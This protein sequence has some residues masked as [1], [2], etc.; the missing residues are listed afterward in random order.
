MRI[1]IVDDEQE[2]VNSLQH[3]FSKKG[4]NVDT[5]ING[6]QAL[7]FIASKEYDFIFL[8]HNMPELT[9]LEV[10]KQMKKNGVKAKTYMLTAYRE[11]DADLALAVGADGYLE[12]PLDLNCLND[13]VFKSK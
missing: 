3:F 12:K 2:I 10:I 4:C 6:K 8:D 9:G 13:I 5:A 1:L 11:I 7:D